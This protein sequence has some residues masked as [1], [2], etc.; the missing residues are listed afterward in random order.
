MRTGNPGPPTQA[1]SE[2]LMAKTLDNPTQQPAMAGS[3]KCE[4]V[5]RKEISG[6]AQGAVKQ[7]IG[8]DKCDWVVR[9]QGATAATGKTIRDV[10]ADKCD[11]VVSTQATEG[12]RALKPG[13]DKCDWVVK[14]RPDETSR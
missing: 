12:A 6:A 8:P 5:V 14:N 9:A 2:V 1:T 4:W 3:D 10:G 7:P 13:P 11:W